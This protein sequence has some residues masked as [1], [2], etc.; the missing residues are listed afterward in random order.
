MYSRM[1]KGCPLDVTSLSQPLDGETN[2]VCI[3]GKRRT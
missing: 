3:D 2:F 1:Y